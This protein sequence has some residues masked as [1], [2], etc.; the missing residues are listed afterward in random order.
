M[1]NGVHKDR[2]KARDE[3]FLHRA[4]HTLLNIAVDWTRGDSAS[5]LACTQALMV[6]MFLG[7]WIMSWRMVIDQIDLKQLRAF[8]QR[9]CRQCSLQAWCHFV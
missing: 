9:C 2:S 1:Y 5:F 6:L 8:C 7:S 3:A 4:A